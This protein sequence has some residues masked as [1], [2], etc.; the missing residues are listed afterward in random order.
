MD[1]KTTGAG[2]FAAFDL[3]AVPSP[4]FVIDKQKIIE[5]LSVLSQLQAESGAQGVFH[6]GDG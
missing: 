3:Q 6:V 2:R 1:T 4:A 5:N